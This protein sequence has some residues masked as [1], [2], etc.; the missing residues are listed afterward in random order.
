MFATLAQRA[1]RRQPFCSSYLAVLV[2]DVEKPFLVTKK[3]R[4]VLKYSA[5]KF[6]PCLRVHLSLYRAR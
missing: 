2:P 1:R 6:Q 3:L 4:L 5:N